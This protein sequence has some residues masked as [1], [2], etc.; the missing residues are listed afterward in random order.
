ML[1]F[2]LNYQVLFCFNFVELIELLE[3]KR[4]C[5]DKHKILKSRTKCPLILLK[6]RALIKC[7]LLFAHCNFLKYK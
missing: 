6:Q 3:I 1:I 2:K 4:K 7:L 5:F